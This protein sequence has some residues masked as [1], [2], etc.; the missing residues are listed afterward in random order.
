M[1]RAHPVLVVIVAA[2]LGALATAARLPATAAFL[3]ADGYEDRY[4]LPQPAWLVVMSLGHREALADLLWM[5]L[6]VYYGEELGHQGHERHIFDYAEAILALD[7]DYLPVYRRVGT[8]GIYRAQAPPLEDVERAAALMERGAARFPNDGPLMW[9]TGATLAFELPPLYR[10]HPDQQEH[11]RERAAPYLIRAS[12]LGAAPP[13]AV[14]SSATMLARIG[15][16]EEAATHLEEMYAITDD[17]DLRAE[18][19]GNIEHLRSEAFATAFV[20]ENA[21]FESA[22]GRD[23]PYAPAAL[24]DLIGPIPVIDTTAVLRD[25]Y[26]AHALDGEPLLP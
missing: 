17:E 12:Q 11:A 9:T 16:A 6:L 13:Y 10:G 25:G 2:T 26:G 24:Y 14:F 21:R 8:L 4:Y 20:D 23:M 22:W 15:R 19:A 5:R 7:A 3:E 18:I 1:S